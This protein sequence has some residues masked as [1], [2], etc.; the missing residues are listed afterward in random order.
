MCGWHLLHGS[1]FSACVL[2]VPEGRDLGVSESFRRHVSQNH[3]HI[4]MRT[5][6]HARTNI[7][8]SPG[9]V[10]VSIGASSQAGPMPKKP[11]IP[12]DAAPSR[13]RRD[14]SVTGLPAE[15]TSRRVSG[16][17]QA[18]REVSCV[19]RALL[20][21]LLASTGR[22]TGAGIYRGPQ[23]T[24]SRC[25]SQFIVTSSTSAESGRPALW[26]APGGPAASSPVSE[27][28]G[29]SEADSDAQETDA[30]KPPSGVGMD[31]DW[32]VTSIDLVM[33]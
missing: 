29:R 27:A 33:A 21:V 18:L 26:A 4:R 10:I 24:I 14:N 17:F 22:G 31:V 8:S 15:T 12:P 30:E 11:R 16:D 6:M 2:R 13:K 7:T 20:L 28:I 23:P 19:A 5:A 1:T 25:T 32:H 9:A 3:V